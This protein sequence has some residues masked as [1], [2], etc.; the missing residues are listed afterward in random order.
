ML[1]EERL[2]ILNRWI[3]K[4]MKKSKTGG[5]MMGKVFSKRQGNRKER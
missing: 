5:L 4:T 2:E 1:V 3:V